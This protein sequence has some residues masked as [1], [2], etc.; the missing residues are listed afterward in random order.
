MSTQVCGHSHQLL[1]QVQR[2][3]R[4]ED[5]PQILQRLDTYCF[6]YC[7]SYFSSFIFQTTTFIIQAFNHFNDKTD[8]T[9]IYQFFFKIEIGH[10]LF[11]KL[12]IRVELMKGKN[13]NTVTCSHYKPYFMI[14]YV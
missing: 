14:I 7:F 4:A 6:Q 3:I 13:L 9:I 1:L 8:L 2:R 5:R 12:F 10:K 11:L